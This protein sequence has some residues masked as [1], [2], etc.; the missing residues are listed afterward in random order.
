MKT[1]GLQSRITKITKFIFINRSFSVLLM[2]IAEKI[3]NFN[4]CEKL[5]NTFL[6]F[7]LNMRQVSRSIFCFV[8]LIDKY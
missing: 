3:N 2:V 1:Y 5:R 7:P 8:L 6:S 4:P